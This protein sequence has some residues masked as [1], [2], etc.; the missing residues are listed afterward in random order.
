[1]VQCSRHGEQHVKLSYEK[2]LGQETP[3][4]V[5]GFMA[6]AGWLFLLVVVVVDGFRKFPI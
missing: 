6:L 5:L 1:M 3:T 4:S 2:S